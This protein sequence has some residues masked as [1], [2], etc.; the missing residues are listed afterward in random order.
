VVIATYNYSAVLRYA[1]QSVL[2]QTFQDFEV[3]VIGDGCPDDSEIVT[4][5]FRDRRIH[6]H[7]LA[8]NSGSQSLPNNAGIERA[9]GKYVAYLGHDD[10]WHPT[11][12]ELLIDA[13]ERDSADVGNTLLMM[14]RPES[15]FRMLYGLW[16]KD[17]FEPLTQLPP[18]SIMHKRSLIAEVG[19]WKDYRTL[20]N[21]AGRRVCIACRAC[22]KALCIGAASHGFQ[23]SVGIAAQRLQGQTFA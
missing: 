5:S 15:P 7:N 8:E 20:R 3:W 18:S 2:W 9:R 1:L 14:L 4:A 13:L 22:E 17:V 19:V 16:A 21:P 11:Q 12:L 23:V 10:L 6:W